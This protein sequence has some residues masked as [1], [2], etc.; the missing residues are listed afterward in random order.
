MYKKN[1][2]NVENFCNNMG[3]WAMLEKIGRERARMS[4]E[5]AEFIHTFGS[6]N[7]VVMQFK[8]DEL[9]IWLCKK[10]AK[11]AKWEIDIFF[12]AS[13]MDLVA[14]FGETF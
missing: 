9:F 4:V 1:A 2:D 8:A 13:P 12:L 10:G 3:I 7:F 11:N 6:L 14:Y 5:K